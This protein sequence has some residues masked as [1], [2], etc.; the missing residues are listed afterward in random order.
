MINCKAKKKFCFRWVS[1]GKNVIQ[2]EWVTEK[3]SI[4]QLPTW[5]EI[6][7]DQKEKEVDKLEPGK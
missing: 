2:S 5:I 6:C 1:K 3:R 7:E 4:K